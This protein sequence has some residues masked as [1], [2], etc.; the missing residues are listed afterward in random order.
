MFQWIS[1]CSLEVLCISIAMRAAV[2]C[3][4]GEYILG[5]QSDLKSLRDLWRRNV[6][7]PDERHQ[8]LSQI[9]R[10]GKLFL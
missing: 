1:S 2:F 4:R 10:P 7:G 9:C 6:C 3:T 8:A 5:E